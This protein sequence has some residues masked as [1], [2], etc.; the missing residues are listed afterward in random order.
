MP[1]RGNKTRSVT[2][3]EKR[4]AKEKAKEQPPG[5][6]AKKHQAEP[7]GK[8]T[9]K[10]PAKK[11]TKKSL[12]KRTPF[13]DGQGKLLN[14]PGIHSGDASEDNKENHVKNRVGD[15]EKSYVGTVE[16]RPKRPKPERKRWVHK[17]DSIMDQTKV[18][19]DWRSNTEEPGL[20]PE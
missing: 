10:A 5:A 15:P 11:D 4:K 1:A 8:G 6:T 3:K 20:D 13:V 19:V 16:L 7:K 14:I 18:P 17:G 9:S 2:D 12:A